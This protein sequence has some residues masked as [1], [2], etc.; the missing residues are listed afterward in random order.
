ML[1]RLLLKK[2]FFLF[3]SKIIISQYLLKNGACEKNVTGCKITTDLIACSYR[4]RSFLNRKDLRKARKT[5][6]KALRTLPIYKFLLFKIPC[7][8][9]G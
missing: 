1:V 5:I 4:R 7:E 2:D 9:C 6:D 8:L 3:S